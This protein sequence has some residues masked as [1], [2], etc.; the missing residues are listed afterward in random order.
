MPDS[1]FRHF[2]AWHGTLTHGSMTWMSQ[3]TFVSIA[4][5]PGLPLLFKLAVF[6]LAMLAL[7]GMAAP[8]QIWLGYFMTN[9]KHPTH[10]VGRLSLPVLHGHK[11]WSMLAVVAPETGL[12]A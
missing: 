4:R 12:L 6:S 1:R 8:A 5:H 2:Q 11:M 3:C 10:T 9:L 7:T